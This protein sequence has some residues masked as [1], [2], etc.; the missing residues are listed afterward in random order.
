MTGITR[1]L[2][3]TDF[4]QDLS[5]DLLKGS[6]ISKKSAKGQDKEALK[7]ACLG[8]EAVFLNIMLKEMRKTIPKGGIF[9][10][11]IQKDIYTSLFDQQLCQEATK[12][13]SAIGLSDMLFEYLTR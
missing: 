2:N 11:S 3:Q 10:D 1:P 6:G 9:P 13:K 5:L 7:K 4:K 12:T 8:V